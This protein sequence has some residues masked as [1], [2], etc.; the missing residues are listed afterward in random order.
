MG[1]E[2]TNGTEEVPT[3]RP[4]LTRSTPLW[5]V[6]VLIV[7]ALGAGYLLGRPTVPLDNSAEAGFLRDMSAHHSQA[8]DMSLI[9]L[10]KTDEPRLSA[11]AADIT[12]TQQAQIGRMQGWLARWELGARG[13]EPPMTW[14]EGHGGHGGGEVPETMPGWVSDETMAELR[15]AEDREAEIIFLEAMVGH[16]VGGID[17]AEAAAVLAEEPKVV[18][19]A[20]GMAEAQQSEIELMQDMLEER[21]ADPVEID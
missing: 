9:I 4:V 10:E 19:L 20:S 14:M 3:A 13:P 18:R 5:I 6:A 21:G 1:Q 2:Y 17:M 12:R 8:V 16:H 7:V 11:V 15:D